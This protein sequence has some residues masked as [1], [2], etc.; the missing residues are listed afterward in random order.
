MRVCQ[1][2]KLFVQSSL[3]PKALA[4]CKEIGISEDDIYV[5]DGNVEGRKSFQEL[6]DNIKY[7][8]VTK[9]R[10]KQASRNTLAY[11][12]FSSG[13]SGPPKGKLFTVHIRAR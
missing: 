12:V 10:T 2:T 7:S 3:I 6:L 1:P 13:T 4:V 11:L 5:L 8:A 9:V